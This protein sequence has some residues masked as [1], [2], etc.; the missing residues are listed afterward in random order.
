[1]PIWTLKML[2][3]EI[4]LWM[5]ESIFRNYYENQL[6]IRIDFIDTALLLG[7]LN[8][9]GASVSRKSACKL[10]SGVWKALRKWEGILGS[11]NHMCCVPRRPEIPGDCVVPLCA[12]GVEW[13]YCDVLALVTI[14]LLWSITGG[15]LHGYNSAVVSFHLERE[16][17]D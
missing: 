9:I 6:R 15:S 3:G 4:D 7:V 11:R 14:A 8:W 2:K 1:M 17:G 10:C 5:C 12:L 16:T 13:V